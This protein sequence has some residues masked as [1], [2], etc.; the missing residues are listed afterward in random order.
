MTVN[1]ADDHSVSSDIGDTIEVVSLNLAHGRKT[2]ANQMLVSGNTI[3]TNLDDTAAFFNHV[4]PDV[5]AL[6]EVDAPS[7]WS[8]NF[9]HVQYLSDMSRY[10][11]VVHGHHTDS[12]LSTYGTA[13]LSR[14]PFTSPVSQSFS[15][16]PP[17]AT[18]GYVTAGLHLMVAGRNIPITVVSV[19]LDFSRKSVRDSQIQ[20]LVDAS[21]SWHPTLIIM[22]DLNS[23]WDEKGSHVK[24]LTE[25]LN[26]QPFEPDS[27]ILGTYKQASGKR[28]D[29]ILISSDLEFHDYRVLP[30]LLSDHLALYASIRLMEAK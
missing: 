24:A 21:A 25:K 3:K 27:K 9:D 19:H 28:L 1:G 14:V 30:D 13:L 7:R 16:S 5:I 11:Y 10:S 12:W 26:L 18:K 23:E 8:G 17:T 2:A 15:P 4:A 29:W 20:S 22:G 6:Q